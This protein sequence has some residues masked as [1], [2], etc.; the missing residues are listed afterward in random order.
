MN[1]FGRK[2]FQILCALFTLVV[3]SGDLI[4]DSIHDAN[5][6]CIT[7]SQDG[8][9]DSCPACACCTTHNGSAV[10]YNAIALLTP[11]SPTTRSILLSDDRPRIGWVPAIDH[12][13][14]LS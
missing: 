11:G 5:G 13:P 14:Q 1:F 9:H 3:F 2:S 12:P 10:A 7:E 6:A 8:N 4:A